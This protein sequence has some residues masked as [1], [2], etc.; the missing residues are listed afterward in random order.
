MAVAPPPEP[1][2]MITEG[3]WV[4]LMFKQSVAWKPLGGEAVT[5]C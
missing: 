1:L 3:C 5:V 2:G 4:F